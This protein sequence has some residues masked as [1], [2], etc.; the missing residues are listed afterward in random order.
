MLLESNH[1]IEKRS[2]AGEPLREV[3]SA[4]RGEVL[5]FP[6]ADSF[7]Y[8]ASQAIRRKS[9][10]DRDS[11]AVSLLFSRVGSDDDVKDDDVK[12]AESAEHR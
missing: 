2:G 8:G 11:G 3:G 9:D 7:F 4:G 12:C 5:R 6:L 1:D 10:R